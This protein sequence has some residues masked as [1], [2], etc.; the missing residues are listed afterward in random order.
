MHRHPICKSVPKLFFTLVTCDTCLFDA[1]FGGISH[2]AEKGQKHSVVRMLEL[3]G[4][5][6]WWTVLR[7]VLL[8]LFHQ[9]IEVNCSGF[10]QVGL[11]CRLDGLD[12]WIQNIVTGDLRTEMINFGL[13]HFPLL[14]YI[15]L[16]PAKT[17]QSNVERDSASAYRISERLSTLG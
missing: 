2:L 13:A 9:R 8:E 3:V 1:N 5:V 14:V 6:S 16:F 7:R 11:E 12:P 15:A 17:S 10:I 4:I